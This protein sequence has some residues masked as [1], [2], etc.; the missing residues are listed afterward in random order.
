MTGGVRLADGA[1]DIMTH[2]ITA[3]TDTMAT[4][5]GMAIMVMD[6]MDILLTD[7]ITLTAIT[8]GTAITMVTGIAA[9]V[10]TRADIQAIVPAML[11]KE[12]I[13]T[14]LREVIT[15]ARQEEL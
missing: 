2:G 13:I 12:W 10:G 15:T 6:I 4:T 1:T 5:A 7:T 11:E 3:I 9:E 14:D 8:A